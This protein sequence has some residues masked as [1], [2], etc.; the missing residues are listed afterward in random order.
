MC[1]FNLYIVGFFI[2]IN[3]LCAQANLEQNTIIDC[4]PFRLN[5]SDV[6]TDELPSQK[7]GQHSTVSRNIYVDKKGEFYLTFSN[8]ELTCW[9]SWFTKEEIFIQ[10]VKEV[11]NCV[12]TNPEAYHHWLDTIV[13]SDKFILNQKGFNQSFEKDDIE[14]VLVMRKPKYSISIYRQSLRRIVY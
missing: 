4:I 3:I 9:S 11:F 13:V 10:R 6:V 12:F 1:K 7:A 2:G 14:I 8:G 5:V